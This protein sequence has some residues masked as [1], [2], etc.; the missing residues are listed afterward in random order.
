MTFNEALRAMLTGKKVR[1]DCWELN[2]YIML[3]ND[4][5]D[6]IDENGDTYIFSNISTSHDWYYSSPCNKESISKSEN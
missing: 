2:E 1:A 5:N 6:F 4:N 3:D